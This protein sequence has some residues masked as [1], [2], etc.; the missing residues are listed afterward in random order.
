[1]TSPASKSWGN[2]IVRVPDTAKRLGSP[3]PDFA[4]YQCRTIVPRPE[5][6]LEKVG[7]RL[8]VILLSRHKR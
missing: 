6:D 7:M 8:N 3:E 5:L 1:M 2:R 4:S